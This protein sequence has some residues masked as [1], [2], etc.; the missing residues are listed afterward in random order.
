MDV[1]TFNSG[2]LVTNFRLIFDNAVLANI[3]LKK[4]YERMLASKPL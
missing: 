2:L 4:N 3:F 1:L